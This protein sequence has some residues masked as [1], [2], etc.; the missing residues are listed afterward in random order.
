MCILAGMEI[1]LRL[2]D[3]E[4]NSLIDRLITGVRPSDGI[5]DR[6]IRVWARQ[7]LDKLHREGITLNPNGKVKQDVRKLYEDNH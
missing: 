1:V 5:E 2:T 7:N 4:T 6:E 3:D